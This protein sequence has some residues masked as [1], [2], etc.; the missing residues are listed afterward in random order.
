MVSQFMVSRYLKMKIMNEYK[1]LSEFRAEPS[2]KQIMGS[3][4]TIS[5]NSPSE[6]F[7]KYWHHSTDPEISGYALNLRNFDLYAVYYTRLDHPSA[8]QLNCFDSFI[9]TFPRK[10]DDNL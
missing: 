3:S 10:N 9:K 2:F 1:I 6:A 8:I 4:V 7:L 5:A